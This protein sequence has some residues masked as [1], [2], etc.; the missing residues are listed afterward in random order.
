MGVPRLVKRITAAW[1]GLLLGASLLWPMGYGYNEAQHVDMAYVYSAHPF[2]FYR[3]GGLAQTAASAATQSAELGSASQQRFAD[4]AI[5]A[6]GSRPSFAKLGGH[7][8]S[9][10]PVPNPMVAN[11]PLFYWTEAVLLRVPGVSHLAWDKQVW[12]M[13]LLCVLFLLPVPILCWAA[14]RRL[15]VGTTEEIPDPTVEAPAGRLA[16]LAAVVP[17]TIPGLVRDGA[18]VSN[19]SLLI[20]TCSVLLVLC[21]RVLTGDLSRRTAI[22][23]AITLAAAMWTRGAALFLVPIVLGCY[24]A[25]WARRPDQGRAPLVGLGIASAGAAVGSAWW[26]HNWISY[27]DVRTNGFGAVA[28]LAGAP[29][30]GSFTHFLPTFVHKLTENLW[31][32]IGLPRPPTVGAFVEYAWP[33]VVLAGIVAA[34]AMRGKPLQRTRAAIVGGT[35]L[36]TVL[37]FIASQYADYHRY[38]GVVPAGSGRYLYFLIVPIA[39]LAAVGWAGLL[40]KPETVAWTLP[41]LVAAALASQAWAWVAV[42]RSWYEASSGPHAGA[43]DAVVALLDLSPVPVGVTVA[44]FALPV[45]TALVLQVAAITHGLRGGLP[46]AEREA[47]MMDDPEFSGQAPKMPKVGAPKAPKGPKMP[48]G[49]F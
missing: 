37:A 30:N 22:W 46:P 18:S 36:F 17:L 14:A 25:V 32:G 40:R 20:L 10:D 12:L 44:C 27:G 49:R 34:L 21:C 2:T 4:V 23:I 38:A 1:V 5:P 28:H 31:G 41:V 42:L 3:P 35:I 19:D 47:A 7:A 8:R 29:D 26:L 16:I 43:H 15:L 6:R 11:P 45:L 33:L 24:V 48:S 13:R 9:N 39:A